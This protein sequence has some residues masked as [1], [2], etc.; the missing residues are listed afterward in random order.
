M[1]IAEATCSLAPEQY[2]SRKNHRAIDLAVN[3][4]LTYDYVARGLFA[5]MM[6]DLAMI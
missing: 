3:K 6:S 4:A 1:K 2:G 5:P